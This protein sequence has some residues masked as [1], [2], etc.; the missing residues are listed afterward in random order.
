MYRTPA[1]YAI[2]IYDHHIYVVFQLIN[3]PN[4]YSKL[5]LLVFLAYP[6]P[7]EENLAPLKVPLKGSHFHRAL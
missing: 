7:L 2:H 3:A 6:R 4:C 5:C 1:F